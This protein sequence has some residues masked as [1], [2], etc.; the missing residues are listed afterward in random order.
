MF[1]ISVLSILLLVAFSSTSIAQAQDGRRSND[2]CN[3]VT[4]NELWGEARTT[5]ST[6]RLG[7]G[8]LTNINAL[9]AF[10]YDIKDLCERY[11]AE[12]NRRTP[13]SDINTGCTIEIA[14][15][16]SSELWVE[17]WGQAAFDHASITIT[18]AGNSAKTPKRIYNG[19]LIEQGETSPF[20]WYVYA[21]AQRGIYRIDV[22]NKEMTSTFVWD[23]SS[24]RSVIYLNCESG[25]EA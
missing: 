23:V 16:N 18:P 13:Y 24:G 11:T 6:L 25:D 1:R 8:A 10:L 12:L 9:N 4:G 20:R 22:T 15:A 2:W 3:T 17:M 5:E 19:E 7:R 21:P 14:S